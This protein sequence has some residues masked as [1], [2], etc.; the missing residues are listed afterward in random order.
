MLCLLMGFLSLATIGCADGLRKQTLIC[1]KNG[2]EVFRHTADYIGML[3][4]Q[5][6]WMLGSYSTV[7]TPEAGSVCQ[8]YQGGQ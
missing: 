8:V 2:E 1:T 4:K 3:E 7:Y 5:E 6:G